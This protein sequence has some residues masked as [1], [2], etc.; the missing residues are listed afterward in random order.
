MKMKGNGVHHTTQQV[1]PPS[2]PKLSNPSVDWPAEGEEV[3]LKQ[4][5]QSGKNRERKSFKPGSEW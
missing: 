5:K 4:A 1:K 3:G 2:S